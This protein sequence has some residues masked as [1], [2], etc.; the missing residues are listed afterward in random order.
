MKKVSTTSYAILGLLALRPWSAYELSQQVR[1]NLS[2]W[3]PRTE[4]QLYEQPKILVAHGLAVAR[5]ESVGR[6]PRTVY[7]IT[8]AGRDALRAWLGQPSAIYAFEWD[9][10]LRVFF[11]EQG[12]KEQLLTTL[13]DAAEQ[14]RDCVR[15]DRAEMDQVSQPG[16]QYADRAHL[17]GLVLKFEV[18]VYRAIDAWLTW[19]ANEVASW[20][21][22][23]GPADRLAFFEHVLEDYPP[24]IKP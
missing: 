15:T 21:D 17:F 9:A 18:D 8:P 13:R 11:A 3:W 16:Y 1:K 19:A 12:T 7:E 6:R 23:N 4:R 5:R 22:I 10:I 14:L 20:P 24:T 2:N